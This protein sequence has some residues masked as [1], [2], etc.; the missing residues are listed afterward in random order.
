MRESFFPPSTCSRRA[1]KNTTRSLARDLLQVSRR[2]LEVHRE[3]PHP[4]VHQALYVCRPGKSAILYPKGKNDILSF[5]GPRYFLA[6]I[7]HPTAQSASAV[8][9]HKNPPKTP[10]AGTQVIAQRWIP[11][12]KKRWKAGIHSAEFMLVR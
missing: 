5:S 4:L 2:P 11:T 7:N 3:R 10:E 9:C 1:E 6:E 12:I 8:G